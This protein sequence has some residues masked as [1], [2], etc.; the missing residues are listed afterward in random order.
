M[1]PIHFGNP[2]HA[3]HGRV[4]SYNLG[5]PGK[6]LCAKGDVYT[7]RLVFA[8][9]CLVCSV[10]RLARPKSGMALY[11]LCIFGCVRGCVEREFLFLHVRPDTVRMNLHLGAARAQ[12]HGLKSVACA[13]V[14]ANS[15]CCAVRAVP[16]GLS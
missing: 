14:D 10:W 1:F 16:S 5:S 4:E 3:F 7:T 6:P 11:I 9:M 8:F 2:C 15:M 13:C 12:N